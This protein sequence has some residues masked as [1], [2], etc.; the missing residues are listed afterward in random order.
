MSENWNNNE[1]FKSY[2]YICIKYL[3][4]IDGIMPLIGNKTRDYTIY[5]YF[6]ES[7]IELYDL[8]SE[9]KKRHTIQNMEDGLFTKKTMK[10]IASLVRDFYMKQCVPFLDIDR[11]DKKQ[12]LFE[13]QKYFQQK[14]ITDIDRINF[15]IQKIHGK[16][17]FVVFE[18][19]NKDTFNQ[20]DND[21]EN[22]I[23]ENKLARV[24]TLYGEMLLV[25]HKKGTIEYKEK[26]I[27]QLIVSVEFFNAI[28]HLGAFMLYNNDN[29]KQCSNNISKAITHLERCIRDLNKFKNFIQKDITCN[30]L[31]NRINEINNINDDFQ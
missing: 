13:Q 22:E 10:N 18:T 11:K 7:F 14:T 30:D 20:H 2:I 27:I 19:E 16:D 29:K 9:N 28:H 23:L 25:K 15:F 5:I 4:P 3:G 8:N 1:K 17:Y 21:D 24:Y 26:L 12:L 31:K 6:I